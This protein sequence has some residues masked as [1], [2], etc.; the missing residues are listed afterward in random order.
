MTSH[1]KNPQFL[2][3]IY[4]DVPTNF[5]TD[6]QQIGTVTYFHKLPTTNCLPLIE[7]FGHRT[8][9]FKLKLTSILKT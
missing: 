8:S 3:L 6:L 2:G 1:S 7:N 4:R 9:D 5:V